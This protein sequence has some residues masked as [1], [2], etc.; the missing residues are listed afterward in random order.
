MLV[1]AGRS[2]FQFFTVRWLNR[3]GVSMWLLARTASRTRARYCNARAVRTASRTWTGY[4][5]AGV[6]GSKLV[7]VAWSRRV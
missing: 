2:M 6:S 1:E 5:I 3:G 4:C 7:L